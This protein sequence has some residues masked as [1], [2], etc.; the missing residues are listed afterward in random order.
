MLGVLISTGLSVNTFAQQGSRITNAQSSDLKSWIGEYIF[1]TGDLLTAQERK[2]DNIV[3]PAPEYFYTLK[4]SESKNTGVLN[5]YFLAQ[6]NRRNSLNRPLYDEFDCSVKHAGDSLQ[7]Y[8][9]RDTTGKGAASIAHKSGQHLFSLRKSDDSLDKFLYEP[10][11]YK[12][13][14]LE[15]KDKSIFFVKSGLDIQ[16]ELTELTEVN[17]KIKGI[18]LGDSY[19]KAIK[20]LGKPLKERRTGPEIGCY[21][22][23]METE[24]I[25]DY[26]GL[27]VKFTGDSR[28]RNFRVHSMQ[29]TDGEWFVAPGIKIG[30]D[31]KTVRAKLGKAGAYKENGFQILTYIITGN[32]GSASFHFKND[33]LVKIEWEYESC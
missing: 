10:A 30:V 18:G 13:I 11:A 26:S 29:V 4:L 24:L 28:G 6:G 20:Q 16:T 33:K 3:G 22:D 32:D 8:F 9:I 31:S 7:I 15:G 14:S 19:A 12:V 5:C 21:D 23:E 27:I 17:L 2:R 25:A 1:E